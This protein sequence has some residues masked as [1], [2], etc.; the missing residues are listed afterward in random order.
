MSGEEFK[1]L[2]RECESVAYRA[3][4]VHQWAYPLLLGSAAAQNAYA[5]KARVKSSQGIRNKVLGH[6]HHE[7]PRR[8]REDYQPWHVT[9]ACGFRIVKL[10]NAEVPQALNELLSLLRTDLEPGSSMGRLK[11]G[12]GVRQIEFHTSRRL[13]DPLSIYSEVKKVVQNHGFHLSE[14]KTGSSYSSVHVVV[15]CEVGE[16][17]PPIAGCC[18]IQLRSVFEEAWGEIS[19]RL[20]Y[21]PVKAA[22][23]TT[24][25]PVAQPDPDVDF[26]LHLDALKSLT[27][28]CAQYADLINRH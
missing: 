14:S 27:D 28:G 21:A 26:W 17:N 20:R 3:G 8:R 16:E 13:N 5:F 1:D 23:A 2:T 19:H 11:D 4:L 6:R 24:P 22:R 15:E 25:D 10:F 18:E 9:D 7:D 12:T